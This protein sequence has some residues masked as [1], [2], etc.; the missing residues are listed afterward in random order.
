MLRNVF[1]LL[2]GFPGVGKLTIA[3][4]LG[5]RLPARV[6]DNHWVNNP[7]LALL[8]DDGFG[9]LPEAVW[10]QTARVRQAILDT[11]ATLCDPAANFIFTNAGIHGDARSVASYHQMKDAADRRQAHFLP[12]RLVCDEDE[13]VRRVASLERRDRLKSVDAEAARL[14]YRTAAVLDPEHP[15]GL[16]LDVTGSSAAESA[17]SIY[18]RLV[19]M[20]ADRGP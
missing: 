4:D 5:R 7:V 16:T 3:R 19:N 1:I 8:D 9:K 6:I 13:L 10:E 20:T 15:D 11:I 12:V 18:D 2:L 17:Q 14:R